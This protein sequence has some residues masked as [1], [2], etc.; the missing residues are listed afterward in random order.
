MSNIFCRVSSVLR[1]WYPCIL[2]TN[3]FIVILTSLVLTHKLMGE[4][5]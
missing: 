4:N 2:L 1:Y 5:S 3:L